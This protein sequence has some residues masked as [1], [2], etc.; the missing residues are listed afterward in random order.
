[1][2]AEWSKF[3]QTFDLDSYE[4]AQRLWAQLDEEGANPTVLK[5]NTKELYEKGFN[6]ASVARNDEV[7]GYMQPLEIAQ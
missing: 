4:K 7:V 6:F 1:M 5:A 3:C 2:K